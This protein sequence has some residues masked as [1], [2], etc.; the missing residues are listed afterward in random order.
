M[1]SS[2]GYKHH[3]FK[4]KSDCFP[5][6]KTSW[7]NHHIVPCSAKL[8]TTHRRQSCRGGKGGTGWSEV[9]RETL[10]I[11]NRSGGGGCWV[12]MVGIIPLYML[13]E[14]E[15]LGTR[16][17]FL[18]GSVIKN[19]PHKTGDTGSIPGRGRSHIPQKN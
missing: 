15:D 2:S 8:L 1:L 6:K 7:E 18:G 10:H 17:G 5:H 13:H 9:K 14:A 19:P 12:T 16:Q 4:V 11:Q 3:P